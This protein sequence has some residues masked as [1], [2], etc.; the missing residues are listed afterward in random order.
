MTVVDQG[1][2]LNSDWQ[3]LG[4]FEAFSVSFVGQKS[5]AQF[6]YHFSVWSAAQRTTN[7]KL[8]LLLALKFDT[9][10]ILIEVELP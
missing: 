3:G 10:M 2:L 7:I 1:V 9:V 5:P 4:G 8:F 6:L